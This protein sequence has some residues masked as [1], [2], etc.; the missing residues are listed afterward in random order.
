MDVKI[1]G[2]FKSIVKLSALSRRIYE[3]RSLSC[4]GSL[5]FS[6]KLSGGIIS[7]LQ[8]NKTTNTTDN[9]FIFIK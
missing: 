3:L 6:T 5:T 4:T 8:E 2:T 7:S 1:L 9:N